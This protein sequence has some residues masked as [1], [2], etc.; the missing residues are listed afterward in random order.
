MPEHIPNQRK[1]ALVIG[2]SMA[3]LFAARVLS[4]HF[5]SVTL[6]ER[7]PINDFPESRKGQAHTRHIHGLLAQGLSIINKYFP[8][9]EEELAEGGAPVA[10]MG[11][12]LHWYQYGDYRKQFKSG[13][14][15]ITLSR[16][17]L[18]LHIRRRVMGLRNVQLFSPCSVRE[19]ITNEDKTQVMGAYVEKRQS[20]DQAEMLAAD[21]IV[22]ASGRGSST[23]KWL[24]TFGYESP[25]EE[26]VKI[27][28][29]YATRIYQ[30]R[31]NPSTT[32]QIHMVSPTAPEGKRG[33]FI[34]PI[35]EDRWIVTAGGASGHYPPTDEEDFLEFLRTLPVTDVFDII[36]HTEPLTDIIP[37]R[38]PLSVRRHYEEL[39]RFPDGYLVIGDAVASFNPIYGQGMTSSAMQAEILDETLKQQRGIGGLWQS[40][41][42]RIAKVVDI[43]WQLAVGEDFRYP[44]TEGKKPPF[45]DL[46]NAYIAKVHKATHRDTVVYGQFLRVVNL[47]APPL[48]LMSPGI[49]WRVMKNGW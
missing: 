15:S 14:R 30:R 1:H 48:S 23:P 44:E 6:I 19:L 11:E 40:F 38:Y 35:E 36:S 27:R 9:I 39:K 29:G 25:R 8:G 45:T 2:A 41:F 17:Y 21:L 34:F 28:V 31:P 32:L 33:A 16:P 26:E 37:Y 5:E 12:V 47:M 49:F 20:E 10:D 4:D 22:D 13:L 7:D 46:L 18:E 43:P 24:E 42:K 3:G